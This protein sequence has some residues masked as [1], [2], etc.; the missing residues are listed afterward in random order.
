MAR[1][2]FEDT[3]FVPAHVHATNS[4]VLRAVRTNK[5]Q[6]NKPDPL[7]VTFAAKLRSQFHRLNRRR[8][9]S[10]IGLCGIGFQS[11]MSELGEGGAGGAAV[12][13]ASLDERPNVDNS[14]LFDLEYKLN[15]GCTAAGTAS[16]LADSVPH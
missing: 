1:P 12:N 16:L 15:E 8:G 2:D 11:E 5:K 3:E 10:C 6:S 7:R 4:R 9:T 14:L 13:V